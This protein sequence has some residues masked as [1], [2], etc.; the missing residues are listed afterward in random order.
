MILSL[1]LVGENFLY[2]HK[3][4]V[5]NCKHNVFGKL[6]TCSNS[7]GIGLSEMVLAISEGREN[8]ASGLLAL[9]VLEIMESIIKSSKEGKAIILES[10]PSQPVVLDW[11]IPLGDLKT[12]G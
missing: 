6:F 12:F 1:A 5:L 11:N 4:A 9:H 3:T 2:A 10:T 8:N 7:R